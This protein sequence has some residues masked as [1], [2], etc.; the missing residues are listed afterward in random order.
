MRR[1][2]SSLALQIRERERR[3]E[4]RGEEGEVG[5]RGQLSMP[6]LVIIERDLCVRY[7]PPTHL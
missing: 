3:K 1:M 4:R 2:I 5:G 6:Q 7:F